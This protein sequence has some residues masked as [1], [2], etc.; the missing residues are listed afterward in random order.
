MNDNAQVQTIACIL[1]LI[2][3]AT[4]VLALLVLFLMAVCLAPGAFL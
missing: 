3:M 4:A 1:T 2:G